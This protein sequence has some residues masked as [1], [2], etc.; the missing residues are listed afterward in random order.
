MDFQFVKW[1]EAMQTAS[2]YIS[3]QRERNVKANVPDLKTLIDWFRGWGV[4]CLPLRYFKVAKT[5]VL[6]VLGAP[7]AADS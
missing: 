4:L 6:I 2:A 7:S 5:Y 1:G 3:R